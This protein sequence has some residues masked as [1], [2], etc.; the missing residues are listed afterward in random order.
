MNVLSVATLNVPEAMLR[1]LEQAFSHISQGL[2]VFLVLLPA[3]A[4]LVTS[5]E[6]SLGS[7]CVG[8]WEWKAQ[9]GELDKTCNS[10]SF[11]EV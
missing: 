6:P 2:G 1:L 10:S 3:L 7:R 11:L 9:L 4:V 8:P 5:L